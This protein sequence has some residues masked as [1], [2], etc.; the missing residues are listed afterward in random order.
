MKKKTLTIALVC[1]L[2]LSIPLTSCIG[3][4]SLTKKVMEWNGEIG[5]KFVNELVFI[6]FWILPVYEVTSI[7]DL[8]VINSIEFWS[9]ENPIAKGTKAID[10]DYGRWLVNCDGKGYTITDETTGRQTR[11]EFDAEEST[12]CLETPEGEM[13]PFM[14]F[15]DD[16][17]VK[18]ITPDGSMKT[19]E[20]SHEGVM[21]Y[22]ESTGYHS[23]VYMASR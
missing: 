22:S 19:I 5:N 15:V 11:L 16:N 10:T 17:H 23:P 7:A 14:T 18:M 8:V 1:M 13:I 12:W 4:F 20:L 2:G 6:A 3:S 21:A 9:G